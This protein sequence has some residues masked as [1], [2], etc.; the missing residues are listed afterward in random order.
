LTGLDM[1]NTG[2]GSLFFD[3]GDD[4]TSF[5]PLFA[6]TATIGS[7]GNA[8]VNQSD[9]S[10][11]VTEDLFLGGYYG[12]IGSGTYNLSGTGNL[13]VSTEYIGFQGEGAFSQSGG[14]HTAISSLVLGDRSGSNGTYD[15]SNGV[16]SAANEWTGYL[17]TGTFSQS[18]GTHTIQ[19]L[20][21]AGYTGSNGTYNLVDGDLTAEKEWI[22]ESGIGT[23]NQSG[24]TNTVQ[25]GLTVAMYSTGYGTYN[26]V[27]GD[28][29]A[30]GPM[31]VSIGYYSP[32]TF[33]Q[34]GGTHTV[35][36]QLSL[37]EVSAGSGTYDLSGGVLTVKGS[38]TGEYVGLYGTGTFTQS[39]GEHTIANI[40]TIAKNDGSSGTYNLTGGVL[41]AKSI[42]NNDTFN[43][44][45][46]SLNLSWNG[47]RTFE[48]NG[49]FNASG[50]GTRSVNGYFINSGTIK[51]TNTNVAFTRTFTNNGEYISDPSN[52]YFT[53]LVIA[54]SGYLVG[55]VG[56]KFYL[57]GNLYNN[58]MQYEGWD[59]AGAYLGF[60]GGG[61]HM[62]F[63]W[64][65]ARL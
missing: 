54:G 28:L 25:N 63:I 47:S 14:T 23:F 34:S 57:S 6:V 15:L 37:G 11:M 43:Y 35:A 59:T 60:R 38:M 27:D 42:V 39:G 30:N 53:N 12:A 58:S 22:G 65:E 48:N 18:G 46:G 61:G 56:D 13:S 5:L 21:V 4:G 36:S 20:N 7:L 44:S 50:T 55:G 29:T 19:W 40:L 64:R 24:G 52:N 2:G 17:G 9:G 51:A 45:G 31:G 8:T 10:I 26:L 33:I 16:L 1:R 3:V 62:S 49:V 32:G 41:T